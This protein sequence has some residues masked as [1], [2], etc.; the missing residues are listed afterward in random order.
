MLGADSSMKRTAAWL[1]RS[2]GFL[3]FA[4]A[5]A[6]TVAAAGLLL[7]EKT[8]W[9]TDWVRASVQGRLERGLAQFDVREVELD[10][11]SPAV[12]LHGLQLGVDGSMVR[13]GKLTLVIDPFAPAAERVRRA[14]ISG[15]RVR[16]SPQLFD[17]LASLG[18][19]ESPTAPGA[20]AN[21]ARPAARVLDEVGLFPPLE[22][23]DVDFLVAHPT[24]GD[25]PL[26]RVDAQMARDATGHAELKGVLTPDL[27]A[28]SDRA[29][30]VF[31]RG[32]IDSPGV[33]LVHLSTGGFPISTAT[34]P[35]GSPLE[36][37]RVW[38]PTGRLAVEAAAQLALDPSVA[39]S[40][41]LRARLSEATILRADT[42]MSLSG[43]EIDL[44]AACARTID[45][46][47]LDPQSWQGLARASG[48]WRETPW[49]AFA[50]LGSA[51]GETRWLRGELAV[52]RMELSAPALAELGLWDAAAETFRALSPRGT[53]NL[54]IGAALDE[55]GR[56]TGAA[57][58]RLEGGLGASYVGWPL[59]PGGAPEGFP[60]AVDALR[61]RVALA[62]DTAAARRFQL[63][64]IGL[65]GRPQDGGANPASSRVDGTIAAARA[66]AAR[67]NQP[68]F[69]LDFQG[70][71]I[72][73]GEPLRRAIEGLPGTAW[74]WPAFAPKGGSI[75]GSGRLMY[76]DAL[77]GVAGG[78][79]VRPRDIALAWE[80]LP[81]AV[82]RAQGRLG[83]HFDPRLLFGVDFEL[84]G[85]T[86]TAES[87]RAAGRI[88]QDPGLARPRSAAAPTPAEIAEQELLTD[89]EILVRGMSLRGSDREV[90]AA[91]WPGV[92]TA[93]DLFQPSGKA[94]VGCRIA[95]SAPNAD[96]QYRV[97][98]TPRGVQLTP[99]SFSTPTRNVVGRVLVCGSDST[100]ATS[101][102][103][104][105]I[106][107]LCGEWPQEARVACSAVFPSAGVDRIEV[108]GAGIDV[109]NR[110]LVGAFREAF[111]SGDG[112]AF[113]LGALSIDGR[114]DF[115]ADVALSAPAIGPPREEG[116]YRV[117][118][119]DNSFRTDAP[120]AAPSAGPTSAGG[121]ALTGLWGEL[122]Q[123]DGVLAGERIQAR[124]GSTPV[125]LSDARFVEEPGSGVVFT[126]R[127][128]AANLPMDREH[129]GLFL[130]AE[131]VD[132]AVDRLHLSGWLDFQDVGL[133]YRGKSARGETML[134]LNGDVLLRD[135]FVDLGL[136]LSIAA[137]D[138][139]LSELVLEGGRVRAWASV[140]SLD[141][142][143][144]NR[145]LEQAKMLVTYV[146]PRLSILDLRGELEGGRLGDM[147]RSA[148]EGGKAPRAGGPAFTMDLL[149]PYTFE[150]GLA[151]SEVQLGGLLRGIF[152]SEFADTGVLD[153][154]IRLK[155]NLDR[156]TGIVGDGFVHMRD[157]RLWSIPVVRDLL[158]QLG[159]DSS[160]VFESM[161]SRFALADGVIR[162][163]AIH[164][165]SP[166]LQLV[167]AGR[168]DLDGRLKHDLQVRYALVDRLGPLTRMVYWVQNNLLS[169][170]VRG[171]M[172]RPQIVLKGALSFLR[173]NENG[174][175]ELPLPALSPLPARF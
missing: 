118:L 86:A 68:E 167:G 130:D 121:F 112:A 99:K 141:G 61:G 35:A 5:C 15:G 90:I 57:D 129:L 153:G 165:E 113:D 120:G 74:I 80:V 46:S 114:I 11:F 81:V 163:D 134:R 41:D 1:G 23:H 47:W 8:G 98:V 39:S 9:L 143:I 29:A 16:L 152:Q 119:R 111:A 72:A 17:A 128:A 30:A 174:R 166:L 31:L 88:Q 101:N 6:V 95:R 3:A 18:S 44:Q 93:L 4:L 24:W 52:E 66:D 49:S 154:E 116:V 76:T 135:A 148:E 36:A 70:K 139:R 85:A 58:L 100:G 56:W 159:L 115:A 173:S 108:S 54:A 155:G 19:S 20:A 172:S 138:V 169:I 67:P 71:A 43:V 105:R 132:A 13:L 103:V 63:A 34:L 51:A 73:V 79:D 42:G 147:A 109:T 140:D 83:L 104:T 75:D 110:A 55:S 106:A 59:V 158:S 142:R 25:F 151:M 62:F 22:V 26:G 38:Q 2:L 32:R 37:L 124:L 164:V 92:G 149:E 137:A 89:I 84:Q 136:P 117:F 91:T 12:T 122:V 96:L 87:L 14:R 157:T 53:A 7:I 69:V 102:V 10:W 40:I 27:A 94:D 160:A 133:E 33:L 123:R 45:E 156:L 107:P 162:M 170:S 175:R 48:V 145:R 21:S 127:V 50:R 60:L 65:E 161:K 171:D 82:E 77:H 126:T 97:E 131:T 78:F 168:L 64:L 150:L 144:A 125:S 28:P 146:Q